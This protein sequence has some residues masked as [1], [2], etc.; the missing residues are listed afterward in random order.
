MSPAPFDAVACDYDATFTETAVGRM[1]R[2]RVWAMTPA[3]APHLA[4]E[5]NCGTGTDALHLARQG[6]RVLATDISP[7]MVAVTRAK[8]RAAGLDGQAA[9]AVLDL[10]NL[11]AAFLRQAGLVA[12]PSLVFSN[13]GGLNCLS[14]A[15]LAA[16]GK[17]LPDL[18]APGGHALVC[19]NSPKLTTEFLQEVVQAE[20]P[21]LV[22]EQRLPNPTGF[23]D[24]SSERALKVLLYRRPST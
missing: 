19:L 9:A 17:K 21:E 2:E 7:K 20:A 12:P 16:F 24:V 4:L 15:D 3:P 22:F 1:Q 23:E 8:L 13:F 11:S 14:P 6:Y 5:L 10:R 18:L